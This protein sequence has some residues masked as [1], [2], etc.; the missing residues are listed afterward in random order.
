M[1]LLLDCPTGLAVR[2]A[3]SVGAAEA[4]T[5]GKLGLPLDLLGL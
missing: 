5:D 2:R 3:V 4:E 1:H